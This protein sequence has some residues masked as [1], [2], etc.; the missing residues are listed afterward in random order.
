LPIGL[1][2]ALAQ[3]VFRRLAFILVLAASAFAAEKNAPRPTT[4]HL[5]LH[6]AIEMALA[7][8]FTLEIQ[9]FSPQIAK[10]NV[11]RRLG[12]FDP[13]F[14]A[15]AAFGEDAS[16]D[17]LLARSRFGNRLPTDTEITLAKKE[18]DLAHV[19]SGLEHFAFDKVEQSSSASIGFGGL[20][21]WGLNYELTIASA[22]SDLLEGLD[23]TYATGPTLKLTQPLL[24]GAGTAANLA[25]LRI[26][27]NNVLVSEWEL[28]QRIM[29]TVTDTIGA[30]ND[31]HLSMENLKVARGFRD[32]ALQTVNDNTKRVEIGVMSPLNITTARAEAARREESV[33]VA[34]RQIKD[35]ANTLKQLIT[36]DLESLLDIELEIEPPP[37]PAFVADVR[38]GVAEALR[39]RPDYRQAIIDIENKH[40]T[41]S[42]T[43]N[44]AL[45]Q[46]DLSA[47]LHLLGI[48][49]DFGTSF[50]RFSRRDQS[51]WSVG[52]IFSVPIP[53]RE[54]RGSV[55]AAKLDAARAL[56][57]LQKLEQD[58]IVK[59]DNANGA[60]ITA[61]QRITSNGEARALAKESLDAGEERLRAGTGTTFEVLELQRKLA[62][63]EAAELKAYSDFNK[64]VAGYQREVGVTLGEHHIQI[65]PPQR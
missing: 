48:D 15:K 9:R 58:I 52:A 37:Q 54:G 41:V 42:F 46:L 3:R 65:D 55:A 7:R 61:R 14:V 2:C 40:I 63:T 16:R 51:A 20:T 13:N 11:T 31:L 22:H 10:E 26:A 18:N 59:V 44:A 35:D 62:E 6:K 56:V 33:I 49:N 50:D 60:V 25:Q 19:Y 39:L 28:R 12:E 27:R 29:D 24:Q 1:K 5:T 34:A 43:K 64:A 38:G 45:P 17:R 36:R 53:N 30:Y 23:N 57:N 21:S 4:L 47:S 32:L 8:N